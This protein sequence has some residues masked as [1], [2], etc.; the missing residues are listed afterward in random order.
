MHDDYI[1]CVHVLCVCMLYYICCLTGSVFDVFASVGGFATILLPVMT[2]FKNVLTAL[3]Q[4]D[5][6]LSIGESVSNICF[7]A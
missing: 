5:L 3:S 1:V 6:C 2:L 4:E 7:C